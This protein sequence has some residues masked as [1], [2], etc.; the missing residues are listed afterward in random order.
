M[1]DESLIDIVEHWDE[2]TWYDRKRIW[3]RCFLSKQ[4]IDIRLVISMV[5]ALSI[6]GILISDQHPKNK[7]VL[8]MVTVL[9]Y[10]YAILIDYYYKWTLRREK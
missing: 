4:K 8:L 3:W 1:V 7:T 9:F 6:I 10:F 2:F 5:V